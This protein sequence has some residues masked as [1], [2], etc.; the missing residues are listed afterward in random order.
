MA[1]FIKYYEI[2]LKNTLRVRGRITMDKF[3]NIVKLSCLAVEFKDK[4]LGTWAY[5]KLLGHTAQNADGTAKT[6]NA[7]ESK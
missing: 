1:I 5:P 3:Q 4:L 6:L 7:A 2:N